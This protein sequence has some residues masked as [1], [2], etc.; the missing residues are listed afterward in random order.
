[1]IQYMTT[2]TDLYDTEN[3]SILHIGTSLTNRPGSM[4]HNVAIGH[5]LYKTTGF[6]LIVHQYDPLVE[7]TET[8]LSN[9]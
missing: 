5:N 2:K 3:G 8:Q 7:H 4:Q 9:V 6:R 1:M